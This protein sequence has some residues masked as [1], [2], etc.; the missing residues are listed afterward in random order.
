MR[1]RLA[2][3][4]DNWPGGRLV[5]DCGTLAEAKRVIADQAIDLLIT[6]L[7]LPDGHGVQAIRLLRERQPAA[8]AMV[9]SVL[10]DD[11]DRD[12]GHRGRRHRL[13]P[14]G[15]R[16]DRHRGGHRRSAGRPLADLLQDRPHHRAPP[17]RPPAA[18]RRGSSGIVRRRPPC[19]ARRV[20]SL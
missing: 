14:E 19:A 16:P 1:E 3:I 9:I 20:P 15:Q 2:R 18:I 12:R 13:P 4:I 5:A 17:Q 10:A 7:N 8:E 11:H 6:D